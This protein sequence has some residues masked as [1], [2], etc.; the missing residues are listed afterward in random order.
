MT[1]RGYIHNAAIGTIAFQQ[2]DCKAFGFTASEWEVRS[3]EL[4]N[5]YECSKNLTW[6]PGYSEIWI[7]DMDKPIDDDSDHKELVLECMD[8]A[9]KQLSKEREHT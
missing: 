4:F 2:V 9:F 8:D 3:M 1:S 5:Q 7:V 6:I